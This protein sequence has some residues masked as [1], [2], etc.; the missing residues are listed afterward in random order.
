MK[1]Y[2]VSQHEVSI[3]AYI[4]EHTEIDTLRNALKN[5]QE[6]LISV[7]TSTGQGYNI[8][9]FTNSQIVKTRTNAQSHKTT[10]ETNYLHVI[11]ARKVK[12]T[13]ALCVETI[14]RTAVF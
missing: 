10:S 14:S 1:N 12:A 9:I 11:T 8:T 5:S 4:V 6:S 2:A 3:R 7:C 13:K